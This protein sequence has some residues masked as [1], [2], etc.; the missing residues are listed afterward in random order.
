[1]RVV[2][3]YVDG[4]YRYE[5]IGWGFAVA[6]NRNLFTED[7]GN[8]KI[9]KKYLFSAEFGVLD[10]RYKGR[11]VC[12][13]AISVVKAIEWI[14]D[15]GYRLGDRFDIFYDY[16]GLE[17]WLVGKWQVKSSIARWYV[18]KM[19]VNRDFIEARVRF[20]KVK[21]HSGNVGH[22]YVDR[23]LREFMRRR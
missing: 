10:N 4:S 5:K 9:G 8:V 22:D 2:D 13:E 19:N 12:G 6:C 16:A 14:L 11:N 17:N 18:S 3:V 23:E 21:G 15:C 7:L 1:M 20:N